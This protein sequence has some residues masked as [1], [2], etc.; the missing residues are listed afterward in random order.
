MTNYLSDKLKVI[1]LAAI[2]LV[3]Y[4][5]SGFHDYPHEILGMKWNHTLQSLV[6]EKLGRCAVPLFFMISGFLFFQHVASLANVW[7]KMKKRV[8]TLVVPFIIAALFYPLFLMAVELIPLASSMSNGGGYNERVSKAD[9]R[10]P[11]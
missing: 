9:S 7:G 8:G 5:H 2:I 6:S 3:L 1:S 11:M 4:I 10:N